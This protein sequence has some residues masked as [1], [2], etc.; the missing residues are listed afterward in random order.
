[1]LRLRALEIGCFRGWHGPVRLEL[2]C[3]ITAIVAENGRGKSSTL[4][5]VE[6]CLYGDAVIGKGSSGIE[7]RQSWEIRPRNGGERAT[8]VRATFAAGDATVE[9]TRRENPSAKKSERSRLE[10]RLPDGSQVVDEAAASEL[11]A[12]GVPDWDT[13]RVAHCFHQE[14]ARRR[15]L[16][17]NDRSALLAAMLGLDE[18]LRVR[19]V[20]ESQRPAAMVGAVDELLSKLENH[21]ESVAQRPLR[22]LQEATA[23]LQ[24]RGLAV[25]DLH[26]GG[27]E[28][29][30][31]RMVE[32]A[33]ALAAKLGLDVELPPP[34]DAGAVAAWAGRWSEIA[35]RSAPAL[36]PL[37]SLRG[38]LARL[39]NALSQAEQETQ[40]WQQTNDALAKSIREGGDAKGRQSALAKALE[41]SRK[42]ED[43]L[44][45]ANARAAVLENAREAIARAGEPEQCPVCDSHVSGLARHVADELARL[46]GAE[47]NVLR[48]TVAA[49]RAAVKEKEL[50]V[51]DLEGRETAA[52]AADVARR[53][54]L[55]ETARLAGEDAAKAHDSLAAVRKRIEAMGAEISRLD[56]LASDRDRE[57][58]AHSD[59]VALLRDFHGWLEAVERAD[60]QVD[61]ESLAA[62]KDLGQAIDDVAGF[63]SDLDALAEIAR[64]LQIERSEARADEVNR[65]LGRYFAL[66][67]RDGSRGG[68]R[69]DSRTT[70]GKVE[71]RLLGD[72]GE[73]ILPLLNQAALNAL[74]LAVLFAQA[75]EQGRRAGF[76]SVL[77]DDPIQSLDDERQIGL[78]D[79]LEELSRVCQVLIAVVPGAF[80][81]RLRTHVTVK[82]RCVTL[83]PWDKTRGASIESEVVR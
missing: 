75:E 29:V 37:D 49:T 28:T 60:R 12:L 34:S 4:N 55:E 36:Q 78:A 51:R 21:I 47:I 9:V 25:T 24:A 79:A 80:F 3:P 83:A 56:A 15:V 11:R 8:E 67:M 73:P 20:L 44:A 77:L 82:R 69:V 18:D 26:A 72:D 31:T 22:E 74:S 16:D 81:E 68:V 40:K 17:S 45:A 7:E 39:K 14:A 71:Y 76:A 13:F 62:W 70:R 58:T 63:A 57:L 35:R 52:R 61:V 48:A 2:D 53:R 30:R 19:E 6:W 10:V 43:A 65:A 64:D 23:R 5:A 59:D 38:Q 66:I 54:V 50:A 41:D 1:M 42:A 46:S 33:R 27:A 32:R